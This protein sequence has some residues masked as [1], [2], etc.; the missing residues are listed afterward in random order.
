VLIRKIRA[1]PSFAAVAF[2]I[3]IGSFELMPSCAR[4]HG[5]CLPRFITIETQALLPGEENSQ[6]VKLPAT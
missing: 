4:V 3:A 2:P 1:I 5:G 6:H